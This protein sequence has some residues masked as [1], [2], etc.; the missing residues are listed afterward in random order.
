MPGSD[1]AAR[2]TE[3]G[4]TEEAREQGIGRAPAGVALPSS[5]ATGGTGSSGSSFLGVGEPA[6]PGDRPDKRGDA[7]AEDRPGGESE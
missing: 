1:E 7:G 6:A 3:R 2:R 4:T 5:D